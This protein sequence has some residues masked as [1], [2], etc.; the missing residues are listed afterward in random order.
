MDLLTIVIGYIKT[1][2]LILIPFS[3]VVGKALK[4]CIESDAKTGAK[5][6][7]K[8][9]LKDT[10]GIKPALYLINFV[11]A[12]IIG[13]IDSSATG[14]KFFAE[15]IVLYGFLHGT[16]VT[17]IATRLYDLVRK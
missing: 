17:F 7:I 14:W 6:F 9:V 12:T 3:W 2:L 10:G 5:G 1:V 4:N 16:V 8:K 15:P 11:L 13:F